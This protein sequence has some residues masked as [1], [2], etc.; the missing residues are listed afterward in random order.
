MFLFL[1]Q[2]EC[3]V[4]CFCLLFD[5]SALLYVSIFCLA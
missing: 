3:I 5:F 4:G 2:L 1:V